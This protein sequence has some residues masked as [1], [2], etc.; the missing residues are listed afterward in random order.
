VISNNLDKACDKLSSEFGN[1]LE[2]ELGLLG[3]TCKYEINLNMRNSGIWIWRP[4]WK[5]MSIGFQF[6]YYDKDL[7]YGFIHEDPIKFPISADIRSKLYDLPNNTQKDSIWWP[8]YRKIEDPFNNWGELEAWK[9]IIDGRMKDIIIE[10]TEYLL[11][12]SKDIK[13]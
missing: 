12:L 3:L 4:E 8:W 5:N 1:L 10:K 2:K 6:Q 13:L 7:F 11:N 9:A